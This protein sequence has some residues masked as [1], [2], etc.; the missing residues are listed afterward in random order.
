MAQEKPNGLCSLTTS[1]KGLT[2]TFEDISI[3]VHGL[4]ED[5]GST[6]LSVVKD[7]FPTFGSGARPTRVIYI[8]NSCTF[9]K[10]DPER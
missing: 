8:L 1:R 3:D 4:G 9:E 6:C 5:Y 7:L 2:V 10:L